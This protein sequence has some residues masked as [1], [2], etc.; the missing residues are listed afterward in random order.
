MKD[1]L[2]TSIKWCAEP[3]NPVSGEAL[4][5]R[6]IDH[7]T[8]QEVTVQLGYDRPLRLDWSEADALSSMLSQAAD[9]IFEEVVR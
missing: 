7:G 8:R 2:S 1:L 3:D 6:A 4:T 9:A 5:V